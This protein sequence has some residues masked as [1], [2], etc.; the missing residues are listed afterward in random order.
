[1]KEKEKE[2]ESPRE[3]TPVGWGSDSDSDAV[4]IVSHYHGRKRRQERGISMREFE[5][6]VARGTRQ[7]DRHG[8]WR[9][10]YKDVVCIVDSDCKHEI[11][12]WR[13]T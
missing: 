11:T 7:P 10:E 9:F 4:S 1:M 5:E 12:S 6:A 13:V 2:K 3:D 8:R